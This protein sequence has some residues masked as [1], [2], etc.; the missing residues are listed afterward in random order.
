M[1]CCCRVCCG[2]CINFFL[3]K[4]KK[5]A[6]CTLL[7]IAI[8]F[9]NMLGLGYFLLPLSQLK[10]DM[11]RGA[12][13][14]QDVAH[15]LWANKT[16][17]PIALRTVGSNSAVIKDVG[18]LITLCKQSSG[19][20]GKTMADLSAGNMLRLAAEHVTDWPALPLVAEDCAALL[21]LR[22]SERERRCCWPR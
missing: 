15:S 10:E 17:V 6:G 2:A 12:A 5:E 3:K 19:V 13:T 8:A 22:C 11:M 9:L 1:F 20:E 16:N 7:Q 4:K 14:Q 21:Q 18:E